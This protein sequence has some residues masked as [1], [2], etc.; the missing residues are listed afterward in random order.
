[1]SIFTRTVELFNDGGIFMW[2]LLGLAIIGIILIIE[3]LLYLRENRINWDRFH[4]ELKG[5]LKE[6]NLERAIVLAAKTKGVI[7]RVMEECLLK[8]QAGETDIESATEK[9]I[10]DEMSSM[11]KS[12]GWIATIIQISPLLGIIGTVQGMIA[13]FMTI[14]TSATTDPKLLASGIYMAL[15]TT[16]AGLVVTIPAAIAQEYFRKEINKI[17]HFMDLYLIEVRE[18]QDKRTATNAPAVKEAAHA[19]QHA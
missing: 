12:R 7:G 3:R 6:N 16:F 18:W 1:M 11:E 9:I 14:E 19:H 17:L 8:I 10:L 13:C 15:I 5:A 4:F 2:P